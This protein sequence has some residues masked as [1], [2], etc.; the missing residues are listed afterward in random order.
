VWEHPGAAISGVARISALSFSPSFRF[1]VP[2][3]PALM[4]NQNAVL[5]FDLHKIFWF[6]TGCQ[7]TQTHW[8]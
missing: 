4:M 5:A 6:L 8:R 3:D 1:R 7:R 2:E